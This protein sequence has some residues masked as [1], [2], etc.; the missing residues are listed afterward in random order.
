MCL[1][2]YISHLT[3]VKITI[4]PVTIAIAIEVTEIW[5]H[6]T[7][8]ILCTHMLH[9]SH[10]FMVTVPGSANTEALYWAIILVVVNFSYVSYL[11]ML[12]SCMNAGFY[13][14]SCFDWLHN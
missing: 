1:Y 5:K 14:I 13:V 8:Y 11:H 6:V 4:V 10:N 2:D 7:L 3:A 9:R 12:V